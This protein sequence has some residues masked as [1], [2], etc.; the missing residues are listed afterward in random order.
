VT[1]LEIY[2][3]TYFGVS[4]DDLAKIGNKKGCLLPPMLLLASPLYL[5]MLFT[6]QISCLFIALSTV[7]SK[8]FIK[9]IRKMK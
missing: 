1:E 3:K 2:K 8:L 7:H 5:I 4:N 9:K 6:G